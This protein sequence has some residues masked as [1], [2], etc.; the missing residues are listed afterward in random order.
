MTVRGSRPDPSTL[1]DEDRTGSD[2]AECPY[3]GS[4][5]TTR[6]HPKGPGLCRSMHFCEN[7]EEPF[8][9]FS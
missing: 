5:E 1:G 3:C 4:D 6:D 8:E 9:Q 2:P 7:C